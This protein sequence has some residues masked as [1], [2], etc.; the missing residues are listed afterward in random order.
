MP[1]NDSETAANTAATPPV[2]SDGQPAGLAAKQPVAGMPP[3]KWLRGGLAAALVWFLLLA[4]GVLVPSEAYRQ[5][6]GWVPEKTEQAGQQKE[7]IAEFS[8]LLD[9]KAKT[10]DP[11]AGDSEVPVQGIAVE[12]QK[13]DPP[14]KMMKDSVM[15]AFIIASVSF[16][17]LNI[18]LLTVLAAF[19]GG[20]TVNQGELAGL[21]KLVE[22]HNA[23]NDRT[24]EADK[25]RKRLN[26][27]REHPG[28][29]AL[30]GLVVFLVIVSGLLVAGGSSFILEGSQT[31]Q[32]MQYF[33]LA[34]V[35]SFFGYLA[36]SDP[37]LFT[38]MIE[39]GSARIRQNPP[40]RAALPP[41]VPTKDPE[42]LKD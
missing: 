29:S 32:L 35:F 33:R 41:R 5:G 34:G 6:L 9:E 31:A 42:R 28:Y 2:T 12:K 8:K 1:G 39:F 14:K 23:E 19:I 15:T 40:D 20:C 7:L 24:T 22:E 30:R 11:K 17:P 37:T 38:S 25:D 3:P 36:G 16:L 18:C 21:E 26:Y 13:P 10:T 4:I 27:L